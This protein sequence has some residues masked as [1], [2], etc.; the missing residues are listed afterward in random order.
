L[1]KPYGVW[2][3]VNPNEYVFL[4]LLVF[5]VNGAVAFYMVRRLRYR[6]SS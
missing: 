5:L 2:C 3:A 6:Q 1:R 4:P